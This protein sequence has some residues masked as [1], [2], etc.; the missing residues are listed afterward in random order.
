M[1]RENRIN[2]K[3]EIIEVAT[4][5]FLEKGYS[6]VLISDIADRLGISKGNLTFHFPTKEHMLAE[7]IRQLC[8]FQWRLLE[9][10][11]A[12]GNSQLIA[13][14]FEVTAMAASCYE[15]PVAKDLYVSAYVSPMSLRIIRESDTRK[16]KS[17]FAR[18]CPDW[19]DVDFVLAE[20]IVSGIEYSV[21]T[22]ER[23]QGIPLDLKIEKALDS[24]MKVYDL[25]EE[26]RRENIRKVFEMDYRKMGVRLL[27]EF[28][29]Y[30]Q[31]VNREALEEAAI[32]KQLRRG[33]NQ[34]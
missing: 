23:D 7:L 10:E 5:L 1:K 34:S 17:V 2:T 33:R 13:S 31:K 20:N 24:I 16:A 14:L 12:T 18:L 29:A 28:R 19:Q 25:P 9:K 22:T 21:F 30:V 8:V 3:L 11:V 4:N 32:Q 27:E 15:N 6:N 26:Q